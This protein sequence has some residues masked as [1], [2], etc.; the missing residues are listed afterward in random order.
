LT[1]L[2]GESYNRAYDVIVS[3]QQLRELEEIIEYLQTPRPSNDPSLCMRPTS[4]YLSLDSGRDTGLPSSATDSHLQRRETMKRLWYARLREVRRDTETWQGILSTHALVSSPKLS[5]HLWIKFS[6][7][8]R[9]KKNFPRAA[10]LLENLLLNGEEVNATDD[11][12]SIGDEEGKDKECSAGPSG[13]C[14]GEEETKDK[15]KEETKEKSKSKSS[16]LPRP[17][18]PI[19]TKGDGK[20][21]FSYLNLLWDE[22]GERKMA[23]FKQMSA[24]TATFRSPNRPGSYSSDHSERDSRDSEG[25]GAGLSASRLEEL[26][27]Q[28]SKSQQARCYAKLAHWNLELHEQDLDEAII[29]AMIETSK[30][31]IE[32]DPDWHKAWRTWAVI[33]Y[34]ALQCYSKKSEN[35][36]KIGSHLLP[37]V[38][39]FIRSISVSPRENLQDTLR[40][41]TLWFGYG[42][43]KEIDTAVR[44]GFKTLNI[45]T[46]L[47]VLPQ[48][49][50][51]IH[52]LHVRA[53]IGHL[54]SKLGEKHPQALVFPITVATKDPMR[55]R[56]AAARKIMMELK[57][58]SSKLFQEAAL[59]SRYFKKNLYFY[60]FALPGFLF[61]CF[62]SYFSNHRNIFFT[63]T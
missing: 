27:S 8:M 35:H 41:L 51:R 34:A 37:A 23:A 61:L 33:N 31:A 18:I 54:L 52:V 25:D 14:Q 38:S 44:E 63:N 46:W 56:V 29:P 49:I 59:V 40:L 11:D 12:Y 3:I 19:P 15:E 57:L 48:L 42:Y 55:S 9:K 20:A 6:N 32:H 50:A 58:H 28:I 30:Q 7:L 43:H 17:I 16:S 10:K 1:T 21:Y 5:P 45:D 13:H 24:W 60:F 39:G 53:G 36:P 2:V 4:P 62:P 22:G 26:E 47:S